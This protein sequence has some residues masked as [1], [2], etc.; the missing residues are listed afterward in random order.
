LKIKKNL[1]IKFCYQAKMAIFAA[2]KGKKNSSL[3]QLVRASRLK[4]GGTLVQ[5]AIK[6]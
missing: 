6:S 3:A 5:T 4:S 2:R 1:A